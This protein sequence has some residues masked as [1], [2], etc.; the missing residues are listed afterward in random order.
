MNDAVCKQFT[1]TVNTI[2]GSYEAQKNVENTTTAVAHTNQELRSHTGDQSINRRIEHITF[3][4]QFVENPD[5][6]DPREF[7]KDKDFTDNFLADDAWKLAHFHLL[8]E[9]YK[10]YQE[11][12]LQPI[13]E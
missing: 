4:A 10:L 6:N 2:R 13:P 3:N 5:P 11:E 8:L 7:K 12:G 1:S 9:H